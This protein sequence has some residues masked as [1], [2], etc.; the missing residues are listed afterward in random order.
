MAIE[1]FRIRRPADLGRSGTQLWR[2]IVA[3]YEL[4][5]DEVRILGDACREADLVDRLEDELQDSPL[6]VRGSMG[7]PAASPLVT[8]IRA[9]RLAIKA[10]LGA[11]KLGEGEAATPR[12][13]RSH[14]GVTPSEAGRRAARAR[15]GTA[16]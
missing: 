11:L 14:R 6:I 9:H 4:R 13:V 8:E 16:G 10:L 3:E 7:Q 2:D 12:G 5:A 15:W 1:D